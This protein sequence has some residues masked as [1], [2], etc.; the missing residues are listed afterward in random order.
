MS[1]FSWI[2]D[3]ITGAAN[4]ISK[5]IDSLNAPDEQKNNLKNIIDTQLND[6]KS[7]VIDSQVEIE[8]EL[9]ERLKIDMTS[10]SWL[11]KNIRPLTLV[12]ILSMFVFTSF[13]SMFKINVDPSFV[14]ILK[15]WG[16]FVF[17]FYFGGRTAEKI[18]SIVKGK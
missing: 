7:K 13:P 9:T 16:Q 12:F 5:V 17:M 11:S 1:V 2:G 15:D 18:S 4:G 6:L 8:K 10:D 3:L 14:T